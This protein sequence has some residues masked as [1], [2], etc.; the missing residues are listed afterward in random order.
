MGEIQCSCRRNNIDC[1]KTKSIIKLFRNLANTVRT[2][3]LIYDFMIVVLSS[4]HSEAFFFISCGFS[5]FS[6]NGIGSVTV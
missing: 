1:K 5:T 3:S 2:Q 6:F 4:Y